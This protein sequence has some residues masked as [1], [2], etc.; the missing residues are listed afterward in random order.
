MARNQYRHNFYIFGKPNKAYA[1]LIITLVGITILYFFWRNAHLVEI[2]VETKRVNA[3]FQTPETDAP[4][5]RSAFLGEKIVHLDLKGAPPKI[6]YYH[7]LFPLLAKLGATGVLIEY[8]DMFPYTDELT[9]ITAYN[10]YSLNDIATINRLAKENNLRVIPLLQTFGHMEFILKLPRYKEYREVTA[11]PQ[12]ICPTHGDTLK[13][14]TEMVKQM[15]QA[16]PDIDM[17]HIGAD[18][19]YYLGICNRCSEF[20]TKHNLSKNL[21]FTEHVNSV[22]GIINR[23]S[24]KLRILMWDDQF[25]SLTE[26]EMKL[27]HLNKGIEPVVWKYTK[28]VYDELGPSL[29]DSYRNVFKKVWVASAFKGATASN[30]FVPQVTHYLEN[31]RSWLSVIAEYKNQFNFEGIIITGWQRYDHFAVLCELLPVG[32]PTLAMS[33]RL[34]LGHTD[35]PLS[36][37]TEIAKILD[38]EQPYALMGPV[39]GTPRC[40]FPGGQILENVIHLQQ[41]IQ[42]YDSIME[43]S[44]VKGWIDDYNI[45]HDF[46]SPSYVESVTGSLDRMKNDLEEIDSDMTV[47]MSEVYDKY[48]VEEWKE[49]YIRPI[50][51]KI[52][53]LY[54]ARQSLLKKEKWPRRPLTHDEV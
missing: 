7:I 23:L 34:L 33:L 5:K 43:D 9:N 12:V 31:H 26:N 46:S 2:S 15:I 48:T 21:L 38:C 20:M 6:T 37:P 13:L 41:L 29:W 22:V 32:I 18:E 1:T 28:D 53:K 24:P 35:S 52:S 44:R 3:N 49:T 14:I 10:S 50:E 4:R 36:P 25:R 27:D 40:D 17:I 19:V 30:A 45:A 54:G 11:Y 39:F 42:E 16:H 47:A 8:E 51:R